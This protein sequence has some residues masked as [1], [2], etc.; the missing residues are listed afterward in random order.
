MKR[1]IIPL[2]LLSTMLLLNGCIGL[3]LGGGT[4]T[5]SHSPTLGEQLIDLKTARDNGA[6]NEAEYQ[7]QKAKLLASQPH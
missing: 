4:R 5:E 3:S 1:F 6:I 7:N 2:T